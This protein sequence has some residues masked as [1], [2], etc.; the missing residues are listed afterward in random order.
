MDTTIYA[1]LDPRTGEVRYIGK[2]Y[3]SKQR[4]LRQHINDSRSGRSNTHA[5]CWVRSL[6]NEGL[7]PVAKTIEVVTEN[8]EDRERY[9]IR[10][11]RK[12]FDLTNSCDGGRGVRVGYKHTAEARA[13]MSRAQ[14]NRPPRGPMSEEAKENLRAAAMGRVIGPEARA[15]LSKA[16]MGRKHTAEAKA[17]MREAHLGKVFSAEHREKIGESTRKRLHSV[18][19]FTEAE[20]LGLRDRWSNGETCKSLSKETGIRENTLAPVLKGN[21]DNVYRSNSPAYKSNFQQSSD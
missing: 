15:K 1:L 4:R 3:R 16:G 7:E 8:W 2:T 5:A 11:F 6:L 21:K 12:R 20:V 9:W 13:N 17:K 14:R 10:Y 19:F 18:T